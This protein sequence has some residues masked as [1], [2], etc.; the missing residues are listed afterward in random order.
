MNP[1]LE[2][3]RHQTR[4]QFFNGSGLALGGVALGLL[5]KRAGGSGEKNAS[6]M[7]ATAATPL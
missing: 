2:F 3:L 1:A 5:G 4:R 7:A 6:R